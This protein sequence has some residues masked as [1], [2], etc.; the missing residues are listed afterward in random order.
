MSLFDSY[1][2]VISLLNY[3]CTEVAAQTG[4]SA[5]AHLSR[6]EDLMELM[7]EIDTTN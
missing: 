2:G 4:E 5:R 7:G 6:I 1:V 3:L